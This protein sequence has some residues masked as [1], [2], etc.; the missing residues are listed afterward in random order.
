MKVKVDLKLVFAVLLL[1]GAFYV[2]NASISGTTAPEQRRQKGLVAADE[3]T[4]APDFSLRDARS[5]HMVRL[6]EAAT[7]SP[8]V[9]TFWASYCTYCPLELAKL[10]AYSQLYKGRIQFYGVNADDSAAA[11]QAFEADRQIAIPTLLDTGHAVE[12]QYDVEQLPMMII[13]DRHGRIRHVGI[14]YDPDMDQSI[15]PMLNNL[16]AER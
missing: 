16:L 15:P 6:Q 14:G 9:F 7:H 2:L 11:A 3:A 13:V 12:Q 10:Q 4:A 8:I 5:G 1:I